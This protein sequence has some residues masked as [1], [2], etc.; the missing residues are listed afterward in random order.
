MSNPVSYELDQAYV[1][2]VDKT[3]GGQ[4]AY[5]YLLKKTNNVMLLGENKQQ[6][7]VSSE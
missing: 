2:V 3:F 4:I 6:E 1:A 5:H 7:K